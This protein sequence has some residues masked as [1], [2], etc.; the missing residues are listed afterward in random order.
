[1]NIQSKGE[2]ILNK[3]K[4]S[5]IIY[6][7]TTYWD[8]I[9]LMLYVLANPSS[10]GRMTAVV[11]PQLM[12][13]WTTKLWIGWFPPAID[14]ISSTRLEDKNQGTVQSWYDYCI[15]HEDRHILISPEGSLK[16]SP[17]RSGYYH[18]SK[19]LKCPVRVIGLDYE[20][21]ELVWNEVNYDCQDEEY[22]IMQ[23][24]LQEVMSSIV[25]LYPEQSYVAVRTHDKVS[26][27]NWTKTMEDAWAALGLVILIYS[28]AVRLSMSGIFHL[29]LLAIAGVLFFLTTV[30]IVVTSDSWLEINKMLGKMKPPNM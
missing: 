30:Y 19:M 1:M 9:L 7:H 26:L 8:F 17:W 5:I 24:T 28:F 11:K 3:P 4:M 29:T 15:K 13:H 22:D 18:L 14:I 10:W 20:Q 27:T 25:P 12:D 6:P 23:D 21:R 16:K 2:A